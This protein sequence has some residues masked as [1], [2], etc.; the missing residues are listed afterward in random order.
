MS[1]VKKHIS[2]ILAALMVLSV[3]AVAPI[4]ASAAVKSGT[5]GDCDWYYYP[6]THSLYI[7]NGTKIEPDKDRNYPWRTTKW[8]GFYDEIE[9]VSIQSGITEIGA[10]AFDTS[11]KIKSVTLPSTL[12]KID[13]CAFYQCTGLESVTF[14]EGL[15]TISFQAFYRCTSLTSVSIPASVKEIRYHAFNRCTSLTEVELPDGINADIGQGAFSRVGLTSVYIPASE[16][17]LSNFSFGYNWT[18]DDGYTRVNGFTIIT[19]KGSFAESY[20]KIN[21]FKVKYL[22]TNVDFTDVLE[23][24]VGKTVDFTFTASEGFTVSGYNGSNKIDWINVTDDKHVTSGEKFE[25]GKEYGAYFT[26]TADSNHAFAVKNGAS[27]VAATVNGSKAI[28]ENYTDESPASTIRIRRRFP[29]IYAPN[30]IS[31]VAVSNIVEP[32][33]G[34]HPV[35]QVT[36]PGNMT[37]VAMNW[38]EQGKSNIMKST[39][40][41]EYGKTYYARVFVRAESG[42]RFAVNS[43]GKTTVL[44]AINGQ[45]A[46]VGSAAGYEQY[47]EIR[48]YRSFTMPEASGEP[49]EI[50]SVE[51]SEVLAPRI[52]AQARFTFRSSGGFTVVNDK[53]DWYCKTDNY[54]L[55]SGDTFEEGKK[56]SA[57]FEITASDGFK[58]AVDSQGKTAV[59][60]KVNGNTA[61]TQTLG[62]Y[63]ATQTI[64]VKYEYAALQP[65]I[66][67]KVAI[68][69]LVE[70]AAGANP[71]FTCTAP[72]GAEVK[73][74]EWI[75]GTTGVSLSA[76]KTFQSG[77]EYYAEI[78][79]KAATGYKFAVDST[80]PSQIKTVVTSTV[81]GKESRSVS[82]DHLDAEKEITIYY[83]FG[84]L[85]DPDNPTVLTKT[86]FVIDEPVVGETPSYGARSY[87]G[88]DSTSVS[89]YNFTDQRYMDIGET[90]EYGKRYRALVFFTADLGYA[91]AADGDMPTI[92][93]KINDNDATV[94]KVS[95]WEPSYGAAAMYSFTT[96]DDPREVISSVAFTGV[97]EPAVGASPDFTVSGPSGIEYKLDWYNNTDGKIMDESDKFEYGKVYIADVFM[98]ADSNHKFAVDSDG[99]YTFTATINGVKATVLSY[100]HYYEAFASS[101]SFT[102]PDAPTEPSTNTEPTTDTEETTPTEETQ[103]TEATEPT[104]EKVAFSYLPSDE[105]QE[106]G[107]SFKLMVQDD[108]GNMTT[109]D[110]TATEE[111][112]NGVT[113]YKVEIP[114]GTNITKV[115]YQIY[116]GTKWVSQFATDP[117]QVEGKVVGSDGAVVEEQTS[118]KKLSDAKITGIKNKTYTG[119]AIS[120]KITLVDTENN[121]TLVPNTDYIVT[122]KNNK[123]VGTA[124]IIITAV[125]DFEGSIIK[126]FKI[127]K[128]KNPIKVKPVTKSVKLKTV[129]K[130]SVTVK[131]AVKVTK[132]QGKLACK[133]TSAPKAI[134]KYLKISSKGVITVKKWAKAKKGSYKIKVKVTAKGTSNYKSKSV[135]KTIKLK[136]K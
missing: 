104:E 63:D 106:A 96:P 121:Y 16:D 52:G 29:P 57:Y 80:K 69:D 42:Y 135:T 32:V 115:Y 116:D 33:V 77:H 50:S 40:I 59:T 8:K 5:V 27:A 56:Y 14:P 123:N 9:E 41:F 62:S 130:K 43:E 110:M 22:I 26:I 71:V 12:K 83:Y 53:V 64:R 94:L 119:K 126:T 6:G 108:K 136:V 132:A 103:P 79:L 67:S 1:T 101:K 45:S 118:P 113:V 88:I 34:A 100:N 47:E 39:D 75:D 89:W 129:K 122:Y 102:M 51:F 72:F 38:M 46:S 95:N 60:S 37:L 19:T 114:A 36:I 127:T 134:K 4:T 81:N 85:I 74:I 93:A 48:I 128:A 66:V 78:N 25:E 70:P 87:T 76:K 105:Q 7:K 3:F 73:S 68:T 30:T 24:E 65:T 28:P 131:G 82:W 21:D 54:N 13:E 2:F 112:I 61:E 117:A 11:E 125:G 15:E 133:I 55:Q 17:G 120:Q 109:Y 124:T 99:K 58:F 91:L 90:Y 97:V 111:K 44:A 84:L 107:N 31:Q 35:S 98:K 20:A 23:P 10:Y 18:K 86:Q 49:I 92:T